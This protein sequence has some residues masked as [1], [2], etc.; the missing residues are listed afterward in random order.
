MT[1]S[2]SKKHIAVVGAGPGGLTSAMILAKRGFKVSIFEAKDRV[3]GRNAAIELG[4]GIG[5]NPVLNEDDEFNAWLKAYVSAW[6][7]FLDTPAS[8]ASA[9]RRRASC[10]RSST[11]RSDRGNRTYSI[12]ARRIIS[13]LVLK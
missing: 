2:A 1:S 3:G 4:D 6:G 13:R 10:S 11:F 5:S 7:E 8:A 9:P 12:T